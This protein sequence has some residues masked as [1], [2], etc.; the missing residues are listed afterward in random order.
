MITF[1][2]LLALLALIFGG[3]FVFTLKVAL[4]VAVVLVLIGLAGGYSLRGRRSWRV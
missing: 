2:I 1:L 4:I 3:F